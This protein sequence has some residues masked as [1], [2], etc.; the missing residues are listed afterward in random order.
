[1]PELICD[2]IE[3]PAEEKLQSV[4]LPETRVWSSQEETPLHWVGWFSWIN[5]YVAGSSEERFT[6]TLAHR[7]E[8]TPQPFL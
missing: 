6:S 8:H 1:M 2:E 3:T 4:C 7:G 5:P